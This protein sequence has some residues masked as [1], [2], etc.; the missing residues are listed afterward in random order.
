[1]IYNQN[2]K[3]NKEAT[4]DRN[5]QVMQERKRQAEEVVKQA[6][7]QRIM[8]EKNAKLEKLSEEDGNET[9]IMTAV[10]STLKRQT[11]SEQLQLQA[12][13]QPSTATMASP[14]KPVASNSKLGSP[15]KPM[16]AKVSGQTPS[17]AHPTQEPTPSPPTQVRK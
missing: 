11:S 9:S 8:M 1:M 13:G 7:F 3:E 2:L 4:I 12:S 17:F 16:P 10:P 14:Q 15:Q 5:D 6:Q